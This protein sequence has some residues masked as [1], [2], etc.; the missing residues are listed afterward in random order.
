LFVTQLLQESVVELTSRQI[1]KLTN[2]LKLKQ[3]ELELQLEGSRQSTEPVTLDQQVV[4]RVSRMDAIQ[5]Q[6]MAI[7]NREQSTLLLKLVS[8]AL[9]RIK[10]GEYGYCLQC[11]EPIAFARLDAQPFTPN[12]LDCQSAMERK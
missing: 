1:N 9:L 6:Q 12:C 8:T 5:Q 7:A 4:G 11:G 10:S 2:H 3:A